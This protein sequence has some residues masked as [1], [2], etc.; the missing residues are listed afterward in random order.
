[1]NRQNVMSRKKIKEMSSKMK[2]SLKKEAARRKQ[3]EH[4]VQ[5]LK[6]KVEELEF[7]LEEKESGGIASDSDSLWYK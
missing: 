7:L 4:E 6:Q 5:R 2:A 3:A 1:M